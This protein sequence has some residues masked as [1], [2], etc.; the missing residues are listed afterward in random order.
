MNTNAER[1]RD[2]NCLRMPPMKLPLNSLC[3]CVCVCGGGGGGGG[4]GVE[5]D[6]VING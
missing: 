1:G 3:V 6:Q 4:G 5:F 2:K